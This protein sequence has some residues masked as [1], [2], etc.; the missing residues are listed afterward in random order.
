MSIR[1]NPSLFKQGHFYH[2]QRLSPASRSLPSYSQKWLSYVI[3][4]MKVKT[5]HPFNLFTFLGLNI[6]SQIISFISHESKISFKPFVIQS[7]YSRIWNNICFKFHFFSDASTAS[8]YQKQI[9][10]H[11][12]QVPSGGEKEH[13]ILCKNTIAMWPQLIFNTFIIKHSG[14]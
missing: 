11:W 4:T 9:L 13:L 6:L 14:F 10:C 7:Q 3:H 12:T 1:E 5:C 8:T 2:A